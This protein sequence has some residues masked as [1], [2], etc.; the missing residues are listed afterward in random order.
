MGVT[1]N[2]HKMFK[3]IEG[4]K[5]KGA[6]INQLGKII[7][8]GDE[9]GYDYVRKRLNI[10]HERKLIKRVTNDATDEYIYYEREKV[11]N[12]HD[13][14]VNNLYAM[15]SFYKFEILDYEEKPRFMN[16]KVIP[17]A[18]LIYKS[19][20]TGRPKAAFCELDLG[21]PT[22]IEKYKLLYASNEIQ[23]EYGDFPYV[24]VVSK[25]DRKLSSENFEVISLDLKCSDFVTKIIPL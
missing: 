23:D 15:F 12:T 21:H 2:D 24:V 5:S 11:P 16:D 1:K 9:N 20:I 17:D 13:C 8:P 14:L 22:K 18:L 25:V 3:I 6:T 4:F 19:K 10:L 7:Y